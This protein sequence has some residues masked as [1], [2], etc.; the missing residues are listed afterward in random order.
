[1]NEIFLAITIRLVGQVLKRAR[2]RYYVYLINV[3]LHV[4]HGEPNYC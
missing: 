4:R 1:M 2:W 3:E